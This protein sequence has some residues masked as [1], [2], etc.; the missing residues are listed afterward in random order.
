M[1]PLYCIRFRRYKSFFRTL[2]RAIE[3]KR[4]SMLLSSRCEDY[5]LAS[6]LRDDMFTLEALY[7]S[8]S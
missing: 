7:D 1:Q 8:L 2:E 5:E 6:R 4:R 3:L